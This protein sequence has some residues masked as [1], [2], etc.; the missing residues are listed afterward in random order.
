MELP[1][2]V[3]V[4]FEREED[5]LPLGQVTLHSACSVFGSLNSGSELVGENERQV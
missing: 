1:A 4:S 2:W 5:L 3:L